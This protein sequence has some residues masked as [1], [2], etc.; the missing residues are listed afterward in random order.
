MAQHTARLGFVTGGTWCLDRNRVVDFWPAEDGLAEILEE[1]AR[2]GG[3]ACNLAFDIRRLD[4]GMFVETIGVVGDDENG[5]LLCSAAAQHGVETTQLRVVPEALTQFTDAYTSRQSGRR[6]HLVRVGVAEALTP[7]DFDFSS[8]RGRILHLGLPGVHARMDRPWGEEA[9][10]WVATLRKARK[11]GLVTNLEL[12]SIPAP[13]IAALVRPC[14]PELDLLIVNDVEIG[15]IAGMATAERGETDVAL[16]LQAA[17]A[18][19][20][21]GAMQ[22]VVAHFPRGAIAVARDG[23]VVAKASVNVPEKEIV[24]ANGAGDAF[25][26]GFLYGFHE[27]WN[28]ERALVLGHAAAAASLRS[29]A[30]TD[31]V[32]PWPKCLALAERWGWREMPA[33]G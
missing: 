13:R 28:L 23:A 21:N 30:T 19:L 14:L 2:G 7:D 20:A 26:A 18:V 25:A 12:C 9:N 16:C 33:L 32:E 15:A 24:G 31:A 17:R 6:T 27:G 1:K 29:I 3:S 10:G 8:T 22:L 4:A 11:A 5:R